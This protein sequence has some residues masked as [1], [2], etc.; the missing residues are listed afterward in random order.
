[1]HQVYIDNTLLNSCDWDRELFNENITMNLD[2]TKTWKQK[3]TTPEA[4]RAKMVIKNY[5]N[6]QMETRMVQEALM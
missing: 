4:M 5:K 2:V 1:M 6:I 3:Y